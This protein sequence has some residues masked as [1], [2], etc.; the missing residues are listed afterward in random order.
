MASSTYLSNPVVTIN[1]VD[2]TDMCQSATLTYMVEA[3]EDTA[4]GTNSRTYTA[5]LVN[6]TVTLTMYASFAA[7]ETYATLFP[8]IGGKTVVTIKPTSGNESATLT[9]MV[10]ALE[11]T[12]FGTNSRTYTAGLV[13]NTV[14]LTMYASFAATETYATL[15]PLIGGKTVVTIKPTSAADSATNPKFILTDC[16][17]ESVPVINASLGELSLYEITFQ[18]GAL[19]IDTTAP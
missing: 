9:Y 3:L 19:T 6:N 18:G 17:L 2:L 8:L 4:F 14:T 5:G 15:F 13:N 7:T 11:D 10:E 12:A 1:A 16:Y